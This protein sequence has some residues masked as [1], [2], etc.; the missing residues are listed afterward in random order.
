MDHDACCEC[1]RKIDHSTVDQAYP[2]LSED[3]APFPPKAMSILEEAI[4]WG[5]ICVE[6]ARVAGSES[7]RKPAT[8]NST[9]PFARSVGKLLRLK[10]QRVRH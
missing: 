10:I 4:Y 1:H 8:Q 5:R 7:L 3:H 9:A 6:C 2:H